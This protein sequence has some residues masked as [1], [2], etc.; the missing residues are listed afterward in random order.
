MGD[1]NHS[2]ATAKECYERQKRITPQEQ[3]DTLPA[4]YALAELVNLHDE[5]LEFEPI[6]RVVFGV[7]P[8]QVLL[9]ALRMRLPRRPA[10]GRGTAMCSATLYRERPGGSHR[11]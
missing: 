8:A 2:L 7:E 4:R 10:R 3:W 6:H 9:A 11:P 1:G 5:S